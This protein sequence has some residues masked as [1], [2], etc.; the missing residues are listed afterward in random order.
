VSIDIVA[1]NNSPIG[2]DDYYEMNAGGSLSIS[3]PGVLAND[4]DPVENDGVHVF[5]HSGGPGHGTLTLNTDGSFVY[6]PDPGFFGLDGFS[7]RPADSQP[8]N[9]TFVNILVNAPEGSESVASSA[10]MGF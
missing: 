8:G 10:L 3:A 7:Y 1:V 9:L 6:T 4:Y 2:E 5:D